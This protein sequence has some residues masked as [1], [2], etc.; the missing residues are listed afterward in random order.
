MD[1]RRI[2]LETSSSTMDKIACYESCD[3]ALA[4]KPW[5]CTI[6]VGSE[7]RITCRSQR[8]CRASVAGGNYLIAVFVRSGDLLEWNGTAMSARHAMYKERRRQ[9]ELSE[10]FVVRLPRLARPTIG[11]C[12]HGEMVADGV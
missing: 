9:H 10:V 8:R 2:H 4:K 11:S 7:P 6:R 3:K 12:C 5:S 1:R